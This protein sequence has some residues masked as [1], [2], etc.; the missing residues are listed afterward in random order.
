VSLLSRLLDLELTKYFQEWV[1]EKCG[2]EGAGR[3]LGAQAPGPGLEPTLM[4]ANEK[5][6]LCFSL[7]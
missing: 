3:K 5:H 4:R 2:G 7:K 6:A 1:P